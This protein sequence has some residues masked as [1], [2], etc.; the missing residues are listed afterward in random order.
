M[1]MFCF[2]CQEASK[3]TGCEIKGVCGK[4]PEVSSLQ[5]LLVYQLKGIAHYANA[6]RTAGIEDAAADRFITEGLFMT[7]TNANFDHER[8]VTY[9]REG[10]KLRSRLKAVLAENKIELEATE[11]LTWLS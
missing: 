8:F 1:N 10:F 11:L 6:L 4:T 3:G 5:D 9:I 2:Q 7:I